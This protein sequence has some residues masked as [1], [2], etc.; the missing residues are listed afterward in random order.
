MASNSGE[1]I[2]GFVLK[3]VTSLNRNELGRG[4]YG[5]VYAIKYCQT[6]C[7]AKEVHSILIEGVGEAERRLTID[8]FLR[9]DNVAC[10]VILTSYSS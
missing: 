9:V 5:K 10:Y 4:A 1:G 2:Q 8:S 3:G 7:A 6:I